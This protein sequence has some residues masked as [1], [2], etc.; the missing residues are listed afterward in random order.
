[1]FARSFGSLPFLLVHERVMYTLLGG[2]FYGVLAGCF[3]SVLV[4][5]LVLD[6]SV[7]LT[8]DFGNEGL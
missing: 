1:M 8:P 7:A 6:I 3:L 2:V 4:S 5:H